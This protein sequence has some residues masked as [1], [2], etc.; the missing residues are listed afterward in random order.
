MFASNRQWLDLMTL[1]MVNNRLEKRVGVINRIRKDE[2]L[3]Q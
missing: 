1:A 2:R 3:R